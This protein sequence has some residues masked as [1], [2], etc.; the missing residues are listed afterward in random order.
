MNRPDE[1]LRYDDGPYAMPG[2]N[3]FADHKTLC[4]TR[5]DFGIILGLNENHTIFEIPCYRILD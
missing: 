3:G 5:H 2:K 1:P 4:A